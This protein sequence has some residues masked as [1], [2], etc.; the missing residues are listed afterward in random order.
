MLCFFTPFLIV[1]VLFFFF[2]I[3][4]RPPGST[5]TDTLFPYTPLFR[6]HGAAGPFR[7]R[8]AALVCAAARVVRRPSSM[9]RGNH[10]SAWIRTIP[11]E[12]ATGKLKEMYDRVRTPHGTVDNVMRVHSRSEEHTSELQSLMRNSYAVFCLKKKKNT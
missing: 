12:R 6:S 9:R 11:I 3:I 5:P 8:C 7:P 1:S 4:R 2:L 10:M